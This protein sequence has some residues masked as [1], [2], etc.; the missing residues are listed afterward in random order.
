MSVADPVML[1]TAR[2]ARGLT[3][4]E[5]AREA[6]LSQ[7]FVSKA[8]AGQV[9]LDGE[10]LSRVADILRYPAALLSLD[11]KVHSLVSTCAFHRKRSSLPVSKI[12]QVHALL[13]LARVQAEALLGEIPGPEVRLPRM[14]PSKAAGVSPRDVARRVR[15]GLG[16]VD[17][18]VQ[19]LTEAV[20]DAGVVILSWD[21]ASRQGDAVSQWLDGHRPIVLMYS[22]APGDR[23]RYSLAHELGHAVMHTEPVDEQEDQADQFASEL[24]MPAKVIGAEL[25]N[26]DMA[27]LARL[28]V[29]WGVSMAA[30]IRRARD[31]GVISD[32]RYKELNIELS[33]A[34]WRSREPVE[35]PPE[36]PQLIIE[37][38]TRLR[39]K[40]LDDL[41]IAE[42]GLMDVRDLSAFLNQQGPE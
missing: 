18:P 27:T 31:L 17:G 28:K 26:L 39:E 13:D 24:L 19:D 34:G 22:A 5:L 14:P 10:R 23:Q 2:Q 20:E 12:K 15:V 42:R 9:E 3:Q 32:Y 41:A 36:H 21:L 37:A 16:L 38:V 11:V 1:A 30:L 8:E 6:G 4:A 33:K 29:R 35:V 40:G 25:G 7:A